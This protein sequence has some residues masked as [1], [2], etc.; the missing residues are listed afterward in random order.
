[1]LAK[2]F[3]KPV[4]LVRMAFEAFVSLDMVDMSE[5]SIIALVNWDKYQNIDGMEKIRNS[6]RE[7]VHRFREKQRL[8]TC[9]VTRNATVTPCNAT[10][11]EL[12]SELDSELDKDIKVNTHT[13]VGRR[14][15][16]SLVTFDFGTGLFHGISDE[17]VVK[18]G[19]AYPALVIDTEL[20]KA[21]AWLQANPAKRKQNYHRFLVNWLGRA[22]ERGGDRV[23]VRR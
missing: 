3:G 18:W 1:M 13:T 16:A 17:Q 15:T 7:R 10:D 21:S 5:N 11:I 23:P 9:N 20:N 6:T 22:Q 19:D 14:D 8:L 2:I 12:D 4:E